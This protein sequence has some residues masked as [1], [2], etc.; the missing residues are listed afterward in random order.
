MGGPAS[1]DGLLVPADADDVFDNASNCVG[2]D[3]GGGVVSGASGGCLLVMDATAGW[4]SWQKQHSA[5]D[6][7]HSSKSM[8]GQQYDGSAH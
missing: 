8:H 6:S 3:G 4:L 5:N 1:D 7:P 2:G